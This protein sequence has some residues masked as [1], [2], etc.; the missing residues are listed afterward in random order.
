MQNGTIT[1]N[2]S[3]NGSHPEPVAVEEHDLLCG[4]Q[5][6]APLADGAR[7][8]VGAVRPPTRPPPE[9][10]AGGRARADQSPE[11]PCPGRPTAPSA[12]A[13]S[14]RDR[15]FSTPLGFRGALSRAGYSP[16]V[17]G[18][19]QEVPRLVED[20]APHLVLL[21]LMLPGTD[22][23]TLMQ[24]ILAR[25]DFPV[26]FLSVY[27]QDE[28]IAKAFEMGG[29]DYVVKP[30]SATELVARIK[31]ALRRRVGPEATIPTEPFV[32]SALKVDCADRARHPRRASGSADG[33]RVSAAL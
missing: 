11:I 15:F 28:I 13:R 12:A 17:T 9:R 18:D 1:L 29:A 16:V 10:A 20:Q 31:P 23:I 4:L 33:D 24:D 30:F 2:G 21:D 8:A 3:R 27:R 22:G 19:P 26:I 6:R 25:A 32:L 5:P 14:A 7:S